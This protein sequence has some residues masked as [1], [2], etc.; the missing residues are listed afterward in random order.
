MNN[1]QTI[2]VIDS[3]NAYLIMMRDI[4]TDVGYQD[5]IC[6]PPRAAEEVLSAVSPALVIYDMHCKQSSTDIQL[7]K[8]L[9]VNPKTMGAVLIV[10]T[11]NIVGATHQ[12]AA[13]GE[14]PRVLLAKPFR[15]ETLLMAVQGCIGAPN[16]APATSTLLERWV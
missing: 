1:Q 16:S 13:L 14:Y 10:C 12:L 2:V 11:T 9:R 7:L 15:L 6:V 8:Q 4:L 5:V 3:D